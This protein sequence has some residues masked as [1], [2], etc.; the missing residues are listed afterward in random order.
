MPRKNS[1]LPQKQNVKPTAS[2]TKQIQDGEIPHPFYAKEKIVAADLSPSIRSVNK[3]TVW[4]PSRSPPLVLSTSSIASRTKKNYGNK[5]DSSSS[6]AEQKIDILCDIE[7][8]FA[9]Q[10][11]TSSLSANSTALS[12]RLEKQETARKIRQ[13]KRARSHDVSVKSEMSD[14]KKTNDAVPN[15]ASFKASATDHTIMTIPS[16]D[17]EPNK[18]ISLKAKGHAQSVLTDLQIKLLHWFDTHNLRSRAM[19]PWRLPVV[20]LHAGSRRYQRV[21]KEG[22]DYSVQQAAKRRRSCKDDDEGVS[23]SIDSVKY[24]DVVQSFRRIVAKAES[25]E[26][27]GSNAAATSIPSFAHLTHTT[28]YGVWV[29]EVMSQQT[30][31]DRA[32]AYWGRW[33]SALPSI[34]A[35]A[36]ASENTVL[37]LWSGLGYYRRARLLH[38]AAKQLVAASS[39]ANNDATE[40]SQNLA[41]Q[42]TTR[43]PNALAARKEE[44]GKSIVLVK[45]EE[46]AKMKSNCSIDFNQRETNDKFEEEQFIE[47]PTEYT[48]LL[49]IAGIG[50]YTAAMVAS[51]CHR[52]PVACVDGNV[53]RVWTRLVRGG[54]KGGL[55]CHRSL[56]SAPH[57]SCC[58]PLTDGTASHHVRGG[59]IDTTQPAAVKACHTDMGVLMAGAPTSP[60]KRNESRD[61]KKHVPKQ[62]KAED[63]KTPLLPALLRPGDWNQAVME[64]GQLLCRGG[65]R[66]G[67]TPLC[68]QCPVR[69]YCGAHRYMSEKWGNTYAYECSGTKK[70][71][72]SQNGALHERDLIIE[73]AIADYTPVSKIGYQK[74]R[75]DSDD[76]MTGNDKLCDQSKRNTEVKQVRTS[77]KAEQQTK[78]NH[79]HIVNRSLF[80]IRWLYDSDLEKARCTSC[81]DQRNPKQTKILLLQRTY[82]CTS[83]TNENIGVDQ[84]KTQSIKKGNAAMKKE[85]R[86]SEITSAAGKDLLVG[87][88]GVPMIPPLCAMPAT[89]NSIDSETDS[90]QLMR[91]AVHD[92]LFPDDSRD[93]HHDEALSITITRP[94]GAKH[95]AGVG[96]VVSHEFSHISFRGSVY[97]VTI[98]RNRGCTQKGIKRDAIISNERKVSVD[99]MNRSKKY[100]QQETDYPCKILEKITGYPGLTSFSPTPPVIFLY[101]HTSVEV[102][103]N[104]PTSRNP[105]ANKRDSLTSFLL[106]DPAHV[107]AGSA[108]TLVTA[109][110]VAAEDIFSL[111]LSTL[112]RKILSAAGYNCMRADDENN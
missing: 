108:Q 65:G 109:Q 63:L 98:T 89:K 12:M 33:M 34:N 32:V 55:L 8:L 42:S 84:Q 72:S 70:G 97:V 50:P 40:L 21:A 24:K 17:D 71:Q 90:I 10:S 47:L 2:R 3:D 78:D 44:K 74:P 5:K 25:T 106:C 103:G 88:W 15:S 23:T 53:L 28:P 96:Q 85:D 30:Q 73:K 56:I 92:M 37:A 31:L 105:E 16:S 80:V 75:S 18:N 9:S 48:S 86:H 83:A 58:T 46:E 29:G 64:L 38:L 81:A 41:T 91:A 101:K 107:N 11:L 77:K 59:R 67:S 54:P 104:K 100:L 22:C 76:W 6:K 112:T 69:P 93:D 79:K 49:Q 4:Y 43:Q 99:A 27:S 57:G 51:V 102:Q 7:D 82:G 36:A 95:K 68:N 13:E 52:E 60:W 35:L 14:E 39:T 61:M 19:V 26:S 111:A 62:L 20:L 45:T 87:L 110:W 94:K 1:G 66:K